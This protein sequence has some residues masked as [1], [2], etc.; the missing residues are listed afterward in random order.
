MLWLLE[1]KL[2]HGD[3]L[4]AFATVD[5]FWIWI[6]AASYAIAIVA[7][8]FA[9][10]IGLSAGGLPGLPFRHV[11]A[12]HWIGHGVGAVLPGHMGEAARLLAIRRHVAETPG[13]ATRIAGSMAAQHILDG[14]AILILVVAVSI[15]I[16][17]PGLLADL[18]WAGLGILVVMPLAVLVGRRWDLARRLAR[19]LPP[20]PRRLVH[21]LVS[22][23][24]VLARR[25]AIPAFGCAAIAIGG[26]F[27]ALLALL[28]AFGVGVPLSAALVVFA[29]LAVAAVVPAAPGGL[30]ARQAAIV[31]PLAT[32]YGVASEQAL[33]LSLGFQAILAGVAV[34]GGLVA[35][36]HQTL[37]RARLRMA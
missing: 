24:G 25:E 2:S 19:R 9:W 15:A 23:A 30:G 37:G 28:H 20:R 1:S 11:A 32:I 34:A 6:G 5:W 10:A 17:V 14:L 18:R 3:L 4:A 13:R 29:L 8:S 33:A 21:G 26:R 7:G 16:P 31:V 12:S 36:A 27:G 22:G 35:L